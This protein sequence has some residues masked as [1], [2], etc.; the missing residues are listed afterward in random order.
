MCEYLRSMWKK[1]AHIAGLAMACLHPDAGIAQMIFKDAADMERRDLANTTT[2]VQLLGDSSYDARIQATLAHGWSV[3]KAVVFV[4]PG[5]DLG[6]RSDPTRSY[7][8]FWSMNFNGGPDLFLA[9]WQGHP[10]WKN[11]T[12]GDL[13]Q[14]ENFPIIKTLVMAMSLD[15]HGRET[16]YAYLAW[17][18]PLVIKAM[19]QMVADVK[20][21]GERIG[22]IGVRLEDMLK[23]KA[24]PLRNKTLLVWQGRFSEKETDMLR[25]TY[26]YPL[27]I[28]PMATII[29]AMDTHDE[30]YAILVFTVGLHHDVLVHDAATHEALY[31]RHEIAGYDLEAGDVKSLINAIGKE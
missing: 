21:S 27:E 4:E 7:L 18:I 19:E 3:T 15:M 6:D 1:I 28:V 17:R 24:A 23:R 8:S 20:Q 11:A 2:Y 10:D 26:P 12:T 13:G 31:A 5:Q 30:H 29:Q 9:F 14:V 16:T 25:K 22:L